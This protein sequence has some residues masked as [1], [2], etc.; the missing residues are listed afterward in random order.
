MPEVLLLQCA[1]PCP[2]RLRRRLIVYL[3]GRQ[4]SALMRS[5]RHI[6]PPLM[7]SF[8]KITISG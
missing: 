5:T 3:I 6:A 1:A 4:A 7:L 2:Q 8:I